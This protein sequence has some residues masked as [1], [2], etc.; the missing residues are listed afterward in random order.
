MAPT[1]ISNPVWDHKTRRRPN[2]TSRSWRRR[3]E[4]C[5]PYL[6]KQS[7]S[8]PQNT[9]VRFLKKGCGSDTWE[10]GVRFQ[11]YTSWCLGCCK[12][13][14]PSRLARRNRGCG[15]D[16]L[17]L[18]CF[19]SI[20]VESSCAQHLPGPETWWR[21]SVPR[22]WSRWS[23]PSALQK[24]TL[25]RREFLHPWRWYQGLLFR[26]RRVDQDLDWKGDRGWWRGQY[27]LW[28]CQPGRR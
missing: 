25:F 13:K 27:W 11:K 18:L 4:Y 24:G 19:I 15:L 17:Y 2:Y 3:W 12:R 1:R 22:L 9:C 6:K 10:W 7:E 8:K 21:N 5:L 28:G 16:D 23:G 26:E 14:S 20:S